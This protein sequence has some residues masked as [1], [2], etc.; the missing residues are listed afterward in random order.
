ME[1]KL[2][3]SGIQQRAERLID[4]TERKRREAQMLKILQTGFADT[5][6]VNP[7]QPWLEIVDGEVKNPT[8]KKMQNMLLELVPLMQDRI[9]EHYIDHL[10]YSACL[11]EAIEQQLRQ[12]GIDTGYEPGEVTPLFLI[13][14]LTTMITGHYARK[15]IYFDILWNSLGLRPDLREKLDPVLEIIDFKG[16]NPHIRRTLAERIHNYADNLGKFQ[17]NKPRGEDQTPP[18]DEKSFTVFINDRFKNFYGKNSS[19]GPTEPSLYPTTTRGL[20]RINRQGRGK[21]NLDLIKIS[22]RNLK[23]KGL[24]LDAITHTAL[25]KLD[26]H[27]WVEW[28]TQMKETRLSTFSKRKESDPNVFNPTISGYLFDVGETLLTNT[29]NEA[30]ANAVATS[31]QVKYELVLAYI[32]EHAGEYT[33]QQD[34]SEF[35]FGLYDYL[36]KKRPESLDQ[37]R[38]PWIHPEMYAVMPDMQELVAIAIKQEKRIG[39]FSNC[40]ATLIPVVKEAIR[41]QYPDFPI[42]NILFSAEEGTKK[43]SGNTEPYQLAADK[44]SLPT[45]RCISFDDFEQYREDA[46]S[47]GMLAIKTNQQKDTQDTI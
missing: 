28:R 42:E 20:Q 37:A 18:L 41:R 6:F 15:D 27:E 30:L 13:H 19:S 14:D 1:R 24:N 36:G 25:E 3:T 32:N 39:G 31:L 22:I 21:K 43:S 26:S 45:E 12:T 8:L 7:T 38:K 2:Y 9:D 4:N 35:I 16:K 10:A 11:G 46:R 17:G 40:I 29:T 5:P 47:T 33:D 34:D 23:S 44:L